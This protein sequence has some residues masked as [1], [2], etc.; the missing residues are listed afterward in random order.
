MQQRTALI[1][2]KLRKYNID[3]AALSET[4]LL[5]ESQLEEVGRGYT[6]F[7]LGKQLPRSIGLG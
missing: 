2:K 4:H 3:I 5:Y 7:G 6:L 1:A